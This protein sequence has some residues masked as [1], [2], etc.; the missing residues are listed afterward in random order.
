M[1]DKD[2]CLGRA[3]AVRQVLCIGFMNQ[4]F[5]YDAFCETVGSGIRPEC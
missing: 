4:V 1:I 3:Y 2:D 5:G